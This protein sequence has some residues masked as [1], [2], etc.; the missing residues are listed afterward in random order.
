MYHTNEYT[1][2]HSIPHG[3]EDYLKSRTSLVKS[4]CFQDKAVQN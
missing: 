4:F 1:K 2:L 3:L